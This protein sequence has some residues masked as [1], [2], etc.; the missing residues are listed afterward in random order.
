MY[1]EAK[2]LIFG[3]LVEVK[4]EL[5]ALNQVEACLEAVTKVRKLG[6]TQRPCRWDAGLTPEARLISGSWVTPR[7][8]VRV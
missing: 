6:C 8:L 5:R 3:G 1:P 7:D 4:K 2:S